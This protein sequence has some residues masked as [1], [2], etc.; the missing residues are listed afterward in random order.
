MKQFQ[1]IV[2]GGGH[3]GVEA[4]LASARIGLKTALVTIDFYSIARM[5]CN[6]AIGGLAKGHLVREIDALGGEMGV[7]SDATGIQFKTLNK[8]KGRSVWSPRAQIDKI[9]YTTLIQGILLKNNNITIIED[10]VVSFIIHGNIIKG[11]KLRSGKKI[12]SE[13]VILSCGTFLNGLVHLGRRKIKSGRMGEEASEG[14]TEHLVSLGFTA[15]RLKTGTPPRINKNTINYSALKSTYGDTNPFP[16]SFRNKK[17]FPPNIPCHIAYT[18]SITHEVIME[19][20]HESPMYCGEIEGIGPRYCP[21]IEDKVVKFSDKPFHQLFLEPEW[22]GSDQIYANGFSTSLPEKIQLKALRTIS[23]LEEVGFIRPGYA[24]EYDFFPP[25]QL[26]STLES[27]DIK[28]LYFA[29]QI[30]GTSGYE[31]AGAQGIIAGINSAQYINGEEPIVLSRDQAYI[32]VLIDDLITKDTIEPYRMFT[33][34]AEFRLMLRH[35]NANRRLSRIG[36]EVGLLSSDD[37]QFILSQIQFVDKYIDAIKCASVHKDIA[38]Q[39]LLSVGESPIRERIAASNLL[40]RPKVC[41][42]H[43]INYNILLQPDKCHPSHLSQEL[44]EEAETTIKYDGYIKRQVRHV[45]FLKKNE[46]MNIPN[47]FDYH[48]ISALS[49]ESKEKLMFVRPENLG[50]ASRISGVSPS[51]ISVLSVL[52]AN[53]Q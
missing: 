20:I 22:Q 17:F 30:N 6:P 40:K 33:S 12:F 43:L 51:D 4:S 24:I 27:K 34:R 39:L 10:E 7:A 2:V 53:K 46:G 13:T 16:F 14:I 49:S 23:G 50:Q 26:K 36:F 41:I 45:A 18:N 19:H 48:S 29:G 21:S 8:S 47:N 1:T 9:K 37:Y 35:S 52:L 31:E 32:G 42:K 28:G 38:N 3:S 15:G 25:S 11:V 44:M 5:S